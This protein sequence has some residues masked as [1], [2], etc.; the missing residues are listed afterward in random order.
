VSGSLFSLIDQILVALVE[1]TM[2]VSKGSSYIF[3]DE[4][5]AANQHVEVARVVSRNHMAKRFLN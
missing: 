5:S 2:R 4:E 1:M 3:H